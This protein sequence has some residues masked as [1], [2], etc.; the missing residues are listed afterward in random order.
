MVLVSARAHAQTPG[1]F[2]LEWQAPPARPRQPQQRKRIVARICEREDHRA[3][4]GRVH[5][6]CGRVHALGTAK[7][8]GSA[9][10]SQ[11][12]C[13]PFV[14]AARA[15]RRCCCAGMQRGLPSDLLS[16]TADLMRQ[17]LDWLIAQNSAAGDYQGS[18][19][20]NCAASVGYSWG[21]MGAGVPRDRALSDVPDA[22]AVDANV[23]VGTITEVDVAGSAVR[24]ARLT[25]GRRR[26]AAATAS[27]AIG[28]TRLAPSAE[29]HARFSRISPHFVLI[30]IVDH[31]LNAI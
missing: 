27:A 29:V 23:P 20:T 17:G 8:D 31:G 13:A 5:R 3:R 1:G 11:R 2:E 19:A 22:A 21:G 16:V 15:G 28:L 30:P 10:C 18:L 25:F 14:C 6:G 26:R 7:E 12:R 24:R 9:C 4:L